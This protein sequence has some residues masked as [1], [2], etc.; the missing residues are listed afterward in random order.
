MLGPLLLALVYIVCT[1]CL[2]PGSILTIGAGWA[3]QQAY[4][5][6]GIA[7]LVGSIAVFIGAWCGSILAF[8]LGKYVFR[9]KS[10]SFAQ[11]YKVTKAL[12]KVIR[13]EG[14]KVVL[15]LRL[16]PLVPFSYFNYAMG[17]TAVSFFDYAVGGLGM[18][19]GTV[20]Y[21]FVGT[22]IGSITDVATGNYDAGWAGITLLIV[23]SVLA[24]A[25]IIYVSVIVKRYLN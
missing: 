11:K 21:V 6:T 20:T 5:S 10:E 9:E 16:C 18:I 7:I 13:Q 1:V 24:C 3:F 4:N 23:G 14:L 12:D 19:P 2:I 22:T 15:L 25:A 17:I 8:F